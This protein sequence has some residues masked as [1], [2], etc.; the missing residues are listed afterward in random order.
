M[1]SRYDD[2]EVAGFLRKLGPAVPE[3]LGLRTYTARLLGADPALVLHGG[4]NTSV[5]AKLTSPIHGEVD[6]LYVKGS[7]WD[8][9][10][11]EPPCHP[12]VRFAPLLAL[13]ALD[14][15]SDEA[16]VNEL[17]GNL[18]DA[19]APTPSVETL[20]HAFLPARFIDHTHAD[21]VLAVCDQPDGEAVCRRIYGDRLVWVPYVMP[22]FALAKRCADAFDAHVKSGKRADVI[23]LERHGIFSFGDTAKESYA[24]M[25]TAVSR[26]EGAI[27]EAQHTVSLGGARTPDRR[28]TAAVSHALRGTLAKLA[29]APPER[30]P[31]LCH[32]ATD[33]IL[34]FVGR[35]DAE[36][37]SAIGCATP[38]HVIRTKPTPLFLRLPGSPTDASLAAAIEEQLVAYAGRYDAYFASMCARKQVTRTKLDPWPRVVLV[39][40]IGLITVG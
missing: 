38:D 14:S 28:P 32:R 6:V 37:L 4:G 5:K 23:V 35:D 1:Q 3:P 25:I 24:R 7:G 39:P 10:T 22:G 21:A 18:L 31:I 33:T 11:I 20:L 19:A 12:A 17:R 16:M 40:D 9:A 27:A 2:A 30:G 15:L 13:R 29:G 36:E 34:R 8:L 26:A